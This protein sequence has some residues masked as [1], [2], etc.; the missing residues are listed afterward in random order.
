MREA[1]PGTLTDTSC[2]GERAKIELLVRRLLRCQRDTL[3]DE[4]P[5]HHVLAGTVDGV[6]GEEAL[7]AEAEHR[8]RGPGRIAANDVALTP[9]RHP[10]DLQLQVPLIAPEP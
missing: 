9:K 4:A 8:A 3:A 2:R 6:H 10:R 7:T 1:L 5:R